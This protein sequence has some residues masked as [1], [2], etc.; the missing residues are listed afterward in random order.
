MGNRAEEF[1]FLPQKVKSRRVVAA[2]AQLRRQLLTIREQLEADLSWPIGRFTVLDY[3]AV[4]FQVGV[5]L[6]MW[7][8]APN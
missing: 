7:A 6:T 3:C 2:G 5:L 8:A 1:D 4:A